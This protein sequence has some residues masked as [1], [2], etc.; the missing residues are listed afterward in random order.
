MRKKVL[1]FINY[2]G[3]NS[4]P[5]ITDEIEYLSNQENI[6]L[7]ILHYGGDLPEKNVKGL[8]MPSSLLPRLIKNPT[9]LSFNYLKSLKYKNGQNASL[10]YLINFFRKNH[11][12]TIYCHFGTNGKL[13]AELKSIGVI[14]NKT[15]LIIRFHG[16]DIAFE[17]YPKGFYKILNKYSSQ[18]LTGSSFG[19]QEL[20]K[21]EIFDKLIRI[22]PV[23]VEK[24]NIR[25]RVN[26]QFISGTV[27]IISVGRLI[28]LKGHLEA[29]EIMR[30]MKEENIDFRYLI[31]GKGPLLNE[32]QRKIEEYELNQNITIIE[33]LNHNET[34]R[35]VENS[36]IYLYP[37]KK[38]QKGRVETQGLAN[39]EA[40][41]LG[42]L[43]IASSV[44]GIPDY[45]KHNET[46]YLCKPGSVEEFVEKIKWVIENYDSDKVLEIRNN[47]LKMVR[48]NYCQEKLNKELL[49][50]L[51]K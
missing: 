20:L 2:Y 13:I 34:L 4:E 33:G 42:L 45:I 31:I 30:R 17:K 1:V 48:E 5:F 44:G 29:I 12:D 19:R 6:D 51:L 7:K 43:V 8:N 49:S 23:G 28:M 41:G 16:L 11:Y 46:G 39:A 38:D 15:Q 26:N 24:K 27:R 36:H 25:E 21:H 40:M 47:A 32:V 14:S 35:E 3:K 37:G 50:F 22:I 9:L 18:I 10:G